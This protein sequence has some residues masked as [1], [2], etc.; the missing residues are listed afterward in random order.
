MR[1]YIPS[2]PE[3]LA[4]LVRNG[5]TS[6]TGGFAVTSGFRSLHPDISDDEELEF[7]AMVAAAAASR[8]HGSPRRVVLAADIPDANVATDG[9]DD[10]R[11]SFPAGITRSLIAS[12]HIDA[13]GGLSSD[14]DDASELLWFANQEFETLLQ[15]RP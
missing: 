1:I 14:T 13:A 7:H 4:A 5:S 6:A 10:G 15:E 9:T 12:A 3:D 11:V 8:A 2:T